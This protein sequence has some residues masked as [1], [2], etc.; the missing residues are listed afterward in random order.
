MLYLDLKSTEDGYRRER[1]RA[2]IIVKGYSG[3]DENDICL[4]AQ[5]ASYSE[6]VRDV[7][8]LRRELDQVLVRARK[9]FLGEPG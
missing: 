6:V 8:F 7:N 2:Q 1:K 5:C 9:Q 3:D 4:S